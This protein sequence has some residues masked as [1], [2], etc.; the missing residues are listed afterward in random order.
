MQSFLNHARLQHG[1][2]FASSEEAILECGVVD[3]FESDDDVDSHT[4][5]SRNTGS[6]APLKESQL[7][8]LSAS[9]NAEQKNSITDA[10]AFINKPR[11]PGAESSDD[12]SDTDSQVDMDGSKRHRS[13]AESA[14]S[15]AA[16]GTAS[17]ENVP[18][19]LGDTR[20]HVIRRV[21]LGNTSRYFEPTSRPAGKENSTHKWTIYLR[22]KPGEQPIGQYVK[23]VRVFLHPSYRPDDIVDLSQPTFELTRWGWGEFPVRIQV[24]FVD[25]RNKPVDLIHI[26]KLDNDWSG[27]TVLGAEKPIDFEI[28]R[29]GLATVGLAT[30]SSNEPESLPPPPSNPPLQ[31]LFTELCRVFPLVLADALPHDAKQP[32]VPEQILELVPPKVIEKWSWGVAVTGEIWRETWPLGRRLATEAHRNR[33][34]MATLRSA[35]VVEILGASEGSVDTPTESAAAAAD[36][37]EKVEKSFQAVLTAAGIDSKAIDSVLRSVRA[38]GPKQHQQSVDMLRLWL[39]GDRAKTLRVDKERGPH[40]EE[41]AWSLK[42]WLRSNG[43]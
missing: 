33:V 3:D 38:A 8:V 4:K 24:F 23:R 11:V 14:K 17:A 42:R 34:L 1:L 5:A 43:F 31:Q 25:K 20:F 7:S 13:K 40:K 19:P 39:K 32:E 29:H 12:G 6:R 41:Y 27:S 18:R 2:E 30:R 36:L 26:L 16:A 37:A 10:L 28:D 35:D 22:N 9:L 21:L 15:R